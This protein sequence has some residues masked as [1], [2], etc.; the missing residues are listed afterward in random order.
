M[1][2][3]H[4]PS[5]TTPER[6]VVLGA[7]GFVGSRLVRRLQEHGVTTLGPT[8]AELDLTHPSSA[9]RLVNLV[10]DGDSI[11]F[12]AAL[13]PDKG[14]D[15]AALMHNLRMAEV[16]GSLKH[17]P[18]QQFIYISSDAVY[19]SDD[20]LVRTTTRPGPA[21]LYGHMHLVR[22]R[23]F[24][25]AAQR[26][27]CPLLVLRPCALY[28]LG[29]THNSYGPNRF[30][31]SAVTQQ[32]IQL[33][34]HGEELRDHLAVDDCVRLIELALHHRSE[35]LLNVATGRSVSFQAIATRIADLLDQAVTLEYQARRTPITH[36]HYD[37][38]DVIRA[39][40]GFRFTD[41]DSGL[42]C[43]LESQRVMQAA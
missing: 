43:L 10:R 22:E 26:W 23:I 38:T 16:F 11:V 12:A 40:P 25:E 42:K 1:I 6:V 30:V 35:G 9:D 13:T 15:V 32:R 14:N 4:S 29:D 2:L 34:G 21:S 28:G 7:S 3:H 37:I 39:F 36:R 33:F 20:S 31:R 19:D 24:A 27:G 5:P 17:C 18:C 41:I 8:S